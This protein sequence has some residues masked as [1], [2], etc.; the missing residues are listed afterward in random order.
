MTIA[1]NPEQEEFIQ[2]QL[3]TGRYA[4]ASDV[5]TEALHLL[6]KQR[7]YDRWVEDVRTK[8]DLAA[9]QLDRGEG[10][11]GETVIAQLKEKMRQA[12]NA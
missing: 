1:L 8:V 4:N 9:A 11:D 5:I 10:V 12:R 3:A 7:E 6:E 2:R